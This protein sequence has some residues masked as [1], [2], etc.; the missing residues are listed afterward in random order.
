MRIERREVE[1]SG[2]Q[3]KHGAH[4]CKA[5]ETACLAF[6]SLKQA[7][8]GLDKAIGLT[9]M[10]PG[11]DA[12]KV[13]SNHARRLIRHSAGSARLPHIRFNFRIKGS[14]RR[15]APA[16]D[17]EIEP[18]Q[19]STKAKIDTRYA[20]TGVTAAVRP[21]LNGLWPVGWILYEVS[22]GN[23]PAPVVQYAV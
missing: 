7:V 23:G 8:D 18:T 1:F 14:L 6:C 22:C 15:A 12:V 3:K 17:P 4:G 11:D 13:V 21:A 16:L 20:T 9:C 10:S 5:K 2:N 19:I